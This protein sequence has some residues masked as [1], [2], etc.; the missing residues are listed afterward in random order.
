M[1]CPWST[2]EFKMYVAASLGPGLNSPG[3][4]SVLGSTTSLKPSRKLQK[5]SRK[6]KS[7]PSVFAPLQGCTCSHC[8]VTSTCLGGDKNKAASK[9][10]KVLARFVETDLGEL[11]LPFVTSQRA[12]VEIK[13]TSKQGLWN[14]EPPKQITDGGTDGGIHWKKTQILQLA[15]RNKTNLLADFGVEGAQGHAQRSSSSH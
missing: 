7:L 6:E 10:N 1:W 4:V 5:F 9:W 2:I 14:L 3:L 15:F 13:C 11:T 12:S 8:L